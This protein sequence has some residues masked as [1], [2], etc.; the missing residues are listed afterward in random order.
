MKD[1]NKLYCDRSII[2]SVIEENVMNYY[3]ELIKRGIESKEAVINSRSYLRGAEDFL[4]SIGVQI[5][6]H[7]IELELIEKL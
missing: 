7:L 6:T 2:F 1:N 5:N 3:D 4:E